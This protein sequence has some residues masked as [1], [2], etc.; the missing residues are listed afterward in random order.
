MIL[1]QNHSVVIRIVYFCR[2]R[3]MQLL[4]QLSDKFQI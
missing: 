3:A 4:E 2:N 1:Y